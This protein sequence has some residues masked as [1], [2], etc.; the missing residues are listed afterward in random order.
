MTSANFVLLSG[1][2]SFGAPLAFAVYEIVATR[3]RRGGGDDRDPPALPGPKPLPDCL[4]PHNLLR[5]SRIRE[6]QDA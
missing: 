1:A 3:R 2:L 6:L 4:Q 5:P